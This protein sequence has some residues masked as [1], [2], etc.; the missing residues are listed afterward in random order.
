MVP[1]FLG[2]PVELTRSRRIQHR[3]KCHKVTLIHPQSIRFNTHKISPALVSYVRWLQDRALCWHRK[4]VGSIPRGEPIVD[5]VFINSSGLAFGHVCDFQ[6]IYPVC[7]FAVVF[8]TSMQAAS[9]FYCKF[10][11]TVNLQHSVN[12]SPVL[13]YFFWQPSFQYFL[14]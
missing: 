13:R 12:L 2:H 7:N 10:A 4:G 8:L 6:S 14:L 1:L 11:V 9:S 3:A 5:D